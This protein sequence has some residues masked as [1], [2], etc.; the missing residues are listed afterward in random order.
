M[1]PKLLWAAG[2]TLL[3]AGIGL[4]GCGVR[5]PYA[6]KYKSINEQ[7]EITLELKANGEGSWASGDMRVSFR[8]ELKKDKI[9]IHAKGGGVLIGTPLGDRLSLDLSGDLYPGCIRG[10]CVE[11]KRLPEGG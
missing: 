10:K 11:F 5:E 8:W 3:L 6:G 2:L 7:P 9:W 1:K 4:V